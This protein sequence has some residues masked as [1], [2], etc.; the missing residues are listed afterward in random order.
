[1]L[2]LC[3]WSNS[4]CPNGALKGRPST[5]PRKECEAAAAVQAPPRSWG[6]KIEIRY[7]EALCVTFLRGVRNMKQSRQKAERGPL[8]PVTF[9]PEPP[10]RCLPFP[11]ELGRSHVHS[12]KRDGE[13]CPW[14]RRLCR[15]TQ[16]RRYACS[17]GVST[18]MRKVSLTLRVSSTRKNVGLSRK[19]PKP[20]C[21]GVELFVAIDYDL[22]LRNL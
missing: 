12:R 5:L 16:L 14:C 10:R 19:L 22:D 1:M 8:M 11:P 20:V 21:Q 13:V 7:A 6:R 17:P 9:T 3:V 2:F 4:S 15:Q 18:E